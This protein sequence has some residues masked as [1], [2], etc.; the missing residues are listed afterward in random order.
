MHSKSEI[1]TNIQNNPVVSVI[2][3]ESAQESYNTAEACINGG[4]KVIELAFTAPHADET[5]ASLS[6]KYTDTDIE[7]GA[8]T[9]LEAETA[10]IAIISGATFIVSPSFSEEVAKICNLYTVPYI[11]GCLTPSDVQS[12]LTY[13]SEIIKLFPGSVVGPQMISELHGPFPQVK[14]M[15]TGGVSLDSLQSWFDA[16]ANIVGVGGQM[17]G[18]AKN[19]DYKGVT[20]NAEKFI[21]GTKALHLIA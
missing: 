9:V 7:I 17:V 5:I 20:K 15:V 2:R 21:K 3:G 1:L 6:E 10:R 16:G 14:V 11:P 4:V 18:P 13:G 19:G 12:A 8:G